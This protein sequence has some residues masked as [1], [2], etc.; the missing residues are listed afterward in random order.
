MTL[1]SVTGSGRSWKYI[2]W[3]TSVIRFAC[4][5]LLLP[6]FS[7]VQLRSRNSFDMKHRSTGGGIETP[8]HN[9]FWISWLHYLARLWE[10]DTVRWVLIW[11]GWGRKLFSSERLHCRARGF[12]GSSCRHQGSVCRCQKSRHEAA[13]GKQTCIKRE[14]G[15]ENCISVSKIWQ[16]AP[17]RLNSKLKL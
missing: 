16:R 7:F 10:Q 3:K 9:L 8:I 13:L 14:N 12:A 4:E 6:S 2:K 11:S 17:V 1:G 15:N 5:C